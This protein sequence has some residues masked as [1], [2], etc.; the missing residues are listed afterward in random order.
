MKQIRGQTWSDVAIGARNGG[1]TLG[2][3]AVLQELGEPKVRDMC[4][5]Q[6]VQQYIVGFHVS[7]NDQRRTIMVQVTESLSGFYGDL[8]PQVPMQ[9]TALHSM[10]ALIQATIR[11]VLVQKQ[12]RVSVRHVPQ[13][14]DDIPVFDSP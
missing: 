8:V 13:K 1:H 5:K 6:L 10:Q 4:L 11:H 3:A 12:I 9:M 7:V 14:P 2:G